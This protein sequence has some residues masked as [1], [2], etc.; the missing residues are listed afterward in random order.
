ME[1]KE[2]ELTKIE[3]YLFGTMEQAEIDAFE[4]KIDMDS[5][6]REKYEF[7]KATVNI[8]EKRK[9]LEHK[10]RLK[11]L[12]SD[13]SKK[14][15]QSAIKLLPLRWMSMAA[16]LILL[17]AIVFLLRQREAT[18]YTV[19]DGFEHL[20]S[21]YSTERSGDKGIA[22]NSSSQ[23]AYGLYEIKSYDRAAPLLLELFDQHQDTLSLLYAGIAYLGNDDIK[24]ARKC[25]EHD[26]LVDYQETVTKYL[27]F[28]VSKE[29]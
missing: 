24:N 28:I 26:A 22:H 13:I 1:I 3:A 23:K 17:A 18:T 9:H 11:E 12:E 21:N 8:I 20:P 10:T 29:D 16:G 5:Q 27:N 19:S 15:Q 25:L 4:W 14:G 7:V 2:D 6:F